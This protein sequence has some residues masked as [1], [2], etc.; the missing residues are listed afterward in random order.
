MLS[1][2]IALLCSL[3]ILASL[4]FPWI[5]T[6]VGNN[7]APW[8]V[9]PAFDRPA[10]EE[11]V[12]GAAPEVL[13]FLVSFLLA[14]FFFLLALLGRERSWLALLTGAVPVG[15]AG[16]MIW[17]DRERLNLAELEMTM[18]EAN[19]LFAEAS[20]VLGMGGWAWIGGAALLLLLG[21]FDPG[22]PKP[23]KVTA[24]RW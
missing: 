7:L 17:Q 15:F 1:R 11:Y 22:R 21:I 10:I 13:V 2:Q 14:G 19:V 9:L 20:A 4:F 23:Q 18:D 8:D 12:R 16:W 3:A 6:P 5:V 24:S